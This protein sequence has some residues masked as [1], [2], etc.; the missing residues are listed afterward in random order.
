MSSTTI[1][2]SRQT[3]ERLDQLRHHRKESYDDIIGRLAAT[4]CGSEMLPREGTGVAGTVRS[5][6]KQVYGLHDENP[7]G[8]RESSGRPVQ[9]SLE[10]R[11][12]EIVARLERLEETMHENTYPPQ[13]AIR[14]E[15]VRKVRKAQADIRKGKG[16]TCDSADDFFQEIEA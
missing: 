5:H 8:V 3:K 9:K 12:G 4:A 11:L 2:L 6:G 14:P 7:G 1:R 15:V 13:S 16:K 10:S